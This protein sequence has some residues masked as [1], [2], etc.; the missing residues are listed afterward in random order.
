MTRLFKELLIKRQIFLPIIS[1]C[2][3]IEHSVHN[4]S[5][6]CFRGLPLERFH[7]KHLMGSYLLSLSDISSERQTSKSRDI[8]TSSLSLLKFRNNNLQNQ[9]LVLEPVSIFVIDFSFMVLP[10]FR[11]AIEWKYLVFLFASNIQFCAC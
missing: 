1:K 5:P 11:L 9:I 3:L 10:F 7:P 8:S 2:F 6:W 4:D